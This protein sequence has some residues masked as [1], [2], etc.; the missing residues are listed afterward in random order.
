[1]TDWVIVLVNVA[2][3]GALL[4]LLRRTR[5][6]QTKS[7]SLAAVA[8]PSAVVVV[9]RELRV[10]ESRAAADGL[11]A[12]EILRTLPDDAAATLRQTAQA[13]ADSRTLQTVRFTLQDRWYAAEVTPIA[14]DPGRAAIWLRDVTEEKRASLAADSVSRRNEAILRSAMDGFFVVSA[15]GR[16]V[17]VNDA[18]CRMLG[19]SSA[20]LLQ[21]RLRDV[22][23]PSTSQTAA[24]R[25][26][27]GHHHVPTG[28]RHKA[29]HVLQL[30]TSVILLPDEG[31]RVMVGFARDAT[32]RLRSEQSL[33]R[34]NERFAALVARMPLGYVAFRSDWAVQE[35]NAAATSIFGH[36]AA[37]AIGRDV[38]EL[39][40][41]PTDRGALEEIHA[42][43]TNGEAGGFALLRNLRA[44][45]SDIRC[46]WFF[47]LIRGAPGESDII[48][49]M[50]RDV[51][52]RERL[53][54]A[55]RRSQKLE[56]LGILAGGV[57]HDF[58]NF[59]VT[60]LCNTSLLNERV[61]ADGEA[62]RYVQRISNASR[63]ASDLTRQMLT[64]AGGARID[65]RPTA[66][67]ELIREVVEYAAATLRPNVKI[68]TE[69]ADPL[70]A[71]DADAGQLHQVVINLLNNA[72]EAIGD[73]P[74]RVRFVTAMRS[75]SGREIAA[76]FTGFDVSAGE[77]VELRVTDDG[78]GMTAETAARIFD[79]F[80]T[81]KFTGRGLGLAM[82]LGIVRA[83]RGCVRVA[84]QPGK[85]TTFFVLLPATRRVAIA[86]TAAPAA[87]P[88]NLAGAPAPARIP[89]GATVL[90]I[91]DEP[92]I[93]DVVSELLTSR[94]AQVLQAADGA[95]G[96]ALFRERGNEIDVVLL[97]LTMP[98]MSGQE[99][100]SRLREIRPDVRVVLS[101]GYS[102][103]EAVQRFSRDEIAGF[104]QKPFGAAA[105]VQGV[106]AAIRPGRRLQPRQTQAVAGDGE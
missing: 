82:I 103:H 49:A 99:V 36:V 73:R 21:M 68:V 25:L 24:S 76:E 18:F 39:L 47:T 52:E 31:R 45:G 32:E 71:I 77:F 30:E 56:S 46:E 63:R 29:G 4:V 69:L 97:D 86:P 83:H 2:V 34:A 67:N 91:D 94:G 102:E 80:F 33:M 106:G 59:L 20:E 100:L 58:N 15:D 40:T 74:G 17:E 11:D 90:V 62:A 98:G 23:V 22:E 6:A 42:R 12:A 14:N 50:V 89:G 27:T 19:Y 78:C 48:A 64:F 28:H 3:L 61:A 37:A 95:G 1:M 10:I 35:W 44:D 79:P 105:L 66:L 16:F 75:L 54:E 57:A 51:S 70:P 87:A 85:G 13:A 72:A 55:L 92:D 38:R 104:V 26:R 65:A 93:R 5:A 88:A 101:S 96:V 60:I 53:E 84:S 81:T 41:A 8:L 7:P 9:D 43:L